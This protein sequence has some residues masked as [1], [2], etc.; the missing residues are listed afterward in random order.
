MMTSW[1]GNIFRVT[2]ISAG[3][4]PAPDEFP[5]RRL[6]TRSFDVYF[7]QRL[8]KRLSKESWG[9]WFETLSRPL[10]RHNNANNVRIVQDGAFGTTRQ[11]ILFKLSSFYINFQAPNSNSDAAQA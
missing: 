3:N 10:W 4:S 2:G 7:D 5:T 9:W 11:I 8:N 6:V 1:N